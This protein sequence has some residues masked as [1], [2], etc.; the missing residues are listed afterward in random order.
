[1]VDYLKRFVYYLI[2]SFWSYHSIMILEISEWH[3][4]TIT[5]VWFYELLV[6]NDWLINWF[7]L[8][9]LNWIKCFLNVFLN[10]VTNKVGSIYLMWL[11]NLW[12]FFALVWGHWLEEERHLCF[13]I[14]LITFVGLIIVIPVSFSISGNEFVLFYLFRLRVYFLV[15]LEILIGLHIDC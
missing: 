2:E 6:K 11:Q 14:F 4:I 10:S 13:A 7:L 1:M 5:F 3:L 9:L 15:E 8:L 12:F